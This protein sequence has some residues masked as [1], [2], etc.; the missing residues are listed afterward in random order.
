MMEDA[1][2]KENL[3][4]VSVS[5]F[6]LCAASDITPDLFDLSLS[7]NTTPQRPAALLESVEMI[8]RRYGSN[9]ITLGMSPKTSAGYV[10]TKIAFARIPD[11]EEFS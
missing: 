11:Q 3:L 5:L 1:T 6:D 2:G 10:G 4:K 8:N 9:T 7:S